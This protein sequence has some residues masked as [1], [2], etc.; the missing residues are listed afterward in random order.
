MKLRLEQR[1]RERRA[2][3]ESAGEHHE[4]KWFGKSGQGDRW[5]FTQ[6]Y[7]GAREKPGFKKQPNLAGDYR[8][9]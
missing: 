2:E 7:W 8:L 4:A 1:Q 6:A 5:E 3:K 9:W